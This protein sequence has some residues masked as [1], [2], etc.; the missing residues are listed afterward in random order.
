MGSDAIEIGV[1]IDLETEIREMK[2]ITGASVEDLLRR[3]E[4]Y[5]DAY[6]ALREGVPIPL[7]KILENGDRIRLIKI[8]SGG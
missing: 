6:L 1:K 8:A 7:T 2:F 4:L 3:L 5:P